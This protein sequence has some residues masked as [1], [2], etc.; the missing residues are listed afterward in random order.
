MFKIA[1][2]LKKN[3]LL[4]L[5]LIFPILLFG[6]NKNNQSKD[7]LFLNN[8]LKEIYKK[9]NPSSFI[10]SYTYNP[11]LNLYIYNV[12]VGDIDIESPLILT[13]DEFKRKMFLEESK[14]YIIKKQK[15]FQE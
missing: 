14:K 7:S 9:Q 2:C 4:I 12:K 10:G 1:F 15:H 6:Q 13:P 3:F 11:E 8:S 5:L